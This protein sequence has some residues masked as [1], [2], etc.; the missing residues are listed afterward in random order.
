MASAATRCHKVPSSFVTSAEAMQLS[1]S[2]ARSVKGVMS[3][4]PNILAL[5]IALN[6]CEQRQLVNVLACSAEIRP[7]LELL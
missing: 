5:G 1:P 2:Q 4:D 3:R 7:M 6:C